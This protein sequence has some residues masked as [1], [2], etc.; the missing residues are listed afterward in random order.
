MTIQEQRQAKGKSKYKRIIYVILS[1]IIG[2]TIA[3]TAYSIS[4]NKEHRIEPKY[5]TTGQPI[6]EL[7]QEH[8]SQ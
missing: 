5:N 1:I 7:Y 2:L 8:L 4:W 6:R 3:Q